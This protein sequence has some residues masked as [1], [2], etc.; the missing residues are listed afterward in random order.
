MLDFAYSNDSGRECPVN[1]PQTSLFSLEGATVGTSLSV[2]LDLLCAVLH[3]FISMQDTSFVL[4]F[5]GAA[6]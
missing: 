6:R 3:D 1:L 2:L 5:E 4:W